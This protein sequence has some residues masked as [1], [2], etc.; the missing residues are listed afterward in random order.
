LTQNI[1]QKQGKV[2]EYQKAPFGPGER[3]G[4]MNAILIPKFPKSPPA[5]F[6]PNSSFTYSNFLWLVACPK[7]IPN[8]VFGGNVAPIPIALLPSSSVPFSTW[9]F[10]SGHEKVARGTFGVSKPNF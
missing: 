10:L 1:P 2:R 8:C 5:L 7:G 6:P 9:I 4:S 3:A